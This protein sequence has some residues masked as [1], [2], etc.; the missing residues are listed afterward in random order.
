MT[1]LTIEAPT[2]ALPEEPLARVIVAE[3]ARDPKYQSNFQPDINLGALLT[4]ERA[5]QKMRFDVQADL[6][7]TRFVPATDKRI[8]LTSDT[9][10]D[11]IPPRTLT[12]TAEM[13]VANRIGVPSRFFAKCSSDLKLKIINEFN[14]ALQKQGFVRVDEN[15]DIRA[16]LGSLYAIL[17]NADIIGACVS[18]FGNVIPK[19]G[20]SKVGYVHINDTSLHARIVLPELSVEI[21]G[22]PVFA[23]VQV[24]NS[25]VGQSSFAWTPSMFMQTCTNGMVFANKSFLRGLGGEGGDG[26]DFSWEKRHTGRDAQAMF[27]QFESSVS[28]MAEVFEQHFASLNK[29]ARTPVDA[30]FIEKESLRYR[31]GKSVTDTI[32]AS[33][34]RA[35]TKPSLFDFTSAL[36]AAAQGVSLAERIR[37]ESAAGSI[38]SRN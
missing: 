32:I 20:K 26:Q 25:E 2:L 16:L 38:L 24:R 1:A 33:V 23:A 30:D 7:Q 9:L 27:D 14:E 28:D 19:F 34:L 11:L 8:A 35:D 17:D 15:G 31:F 21:N 22:K 6:A 13:N 36:T 12:D 10:P 4:L 3:A 5:K 18:T 29:A 37:L